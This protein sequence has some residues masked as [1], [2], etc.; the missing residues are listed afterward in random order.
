MPRYLRDGPGELA[1]RYDFVAVLADSWEGEAMYL[2]VSA[3]K[4]SDI[5]KL[6][7][8]TQHDI[9]KSNLQQRLQGRPAP[10]SSNSQGRLNT[11]HVFLNGREAKFGWDAR[12]CHKIHSSNFGG[13]LQIN[14]KM[15]NEGLE[16][17]SIAQGYQGEGTYRDQK[18]SRSWEPSAR[19]QF[20]D[21]KYDNG[22]C[23]INFS[24]NNF[25]SDFGT[26]D[27]IE[28]R[29]WDWYGKQRRGTIRA[30]LSMVEILRLH[31]GVFGDHS[32]DDYGVEDHYDRRVRNL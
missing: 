8:C 6:R 20:L 13:L 21:T 32:D 5:V 4:N 7:V 9:V 17:V 15:E 24:A 16:G 28:V 25:V 3:F 12:Y 14:S 23:F 30:S 29:V 18:R 26:P 2:N 19:L 1:T 11:A 10:F 31:D 22:Q 27:Y